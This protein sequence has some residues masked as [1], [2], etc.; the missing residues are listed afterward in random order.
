[1]SE[2]LYFAAV[3]IGGACVLAV[4]LTAML[5]LCLG[6]SLRAQGVARIG[7]HSVLSVGVEVPASPH[8]AL[9]AKGACNRGRVSDRR[10][11]SGL[12]GRSS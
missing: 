1:M 10:A 5:A 12:A 4:I 7:A 6:R 9:D 8:L 2:Q 3:V 11:A